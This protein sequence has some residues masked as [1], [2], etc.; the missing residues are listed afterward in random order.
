[1]LACRLERFIKKHGHA[2]NTLLELHVT[3]DTPTTTNAL[4]SKNGIFKPFSLSSK[5]FSNPQRCQK[6]FAGVALYENFD[7]KTRGVHKGTSAMQRAEINLDDF[8]ATNFFSTIGLPEPQISLS[9][10]TF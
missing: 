5:F 6:F 9:E 4:E 8:G 10:I 7:I 1:M 3:Q 2:I